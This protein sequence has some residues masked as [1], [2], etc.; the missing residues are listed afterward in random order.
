MRHSRLVTV[1]AAAR[2]PRPAAVLGDSDAVRVGD[3]VYAIGNPF[4]LE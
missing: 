3:E 2:A 4:G 1:S